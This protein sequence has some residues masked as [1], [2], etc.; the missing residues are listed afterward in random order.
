MQTHLQRM[1]LGSYQGTSSKL[2]PFLDYYYQVRAYRYSDPAHMCVDIVRV[3]CVRTMRML[4]MY[5]TTSYGKKTQTHTHIDT[6]D[7]NV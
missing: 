4:C 7:T 1:I 6:S 2:L 5:G 3:R